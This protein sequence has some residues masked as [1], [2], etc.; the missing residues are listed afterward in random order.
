MPVEIQ[1]IAALSQQ[2]AVWQRLW[3]EQSHKPVDI[4]LAASAVGMPNEVRWAVLVDSVLVSSGN[5]LV[6][7][8]LQQIRTALAEHAGIHDHSATLAPW[9]LSWARNAAPAARD[10]AGWNE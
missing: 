10:T 9:E 7:R 4:V 8:A 6:W 5:A 2:E 1:M 3:Q